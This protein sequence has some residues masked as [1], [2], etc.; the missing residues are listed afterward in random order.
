MIE[1][2][3]Q[4]MNLRDEERSFFKPLVEHQI[5]KETFLQKLG[6]LKEYI[7]FI[8]LNESVYFSLYNPNLDFEAEDYFSLYSLSES[9]DVKE[10]NIDWFQDD[11]LIVLG[12]IGQETYLFYYGEEV[13]VFYQHLEYE[14][15]NLIQVARNLRE[16]LENKT[17]FCKAMKY[18]D[19]LQRYFD[20]DEDYEKFLSK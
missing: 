16:L 4:E 9:Y 19:R 1:K 11:E 2:L 5:Y 15:E 14:K 12:C 17:I 10:G 3:K 6:N 18:S 7:E 8:Q 20:N 13:Y